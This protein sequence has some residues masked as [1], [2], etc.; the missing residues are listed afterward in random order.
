M[1]DRYIDLRVED[2][3]VPIG[4]LTRLL[5]LHRFYLTPP[6]AADLLPIDSAI[7]RELQTLLK[8]TG[9]YAG[10]ISGA[11][12]DATRAALDQYGGVENLEMRLVSPTKIDP[13]VLAYLREK[14]G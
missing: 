10:P 11:Y 1:L 9:Y 14:L 12:D 8:R 2:H 4:E 3:P 7:A 5:K 6:R 13:Q